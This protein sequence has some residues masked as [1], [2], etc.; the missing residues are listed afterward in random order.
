MRLS[1]TI[2]M[3]CLAIAVCVVLPVRAEAMRAGGFTE[4]FRLSDSLVPVALEISGGYLTGESREYVYEGSHK[5]SQLEWQLRDIYMVG[6]NVSVGA[7]DWLVVNVGGWMAVNDHAGRMTDYD[8][9]QEN[10]L[11]WTD[12]SI[13]T[14]KL[15]R[16]FMLDTNV[17]TPL[18]LN[19]HFSVVPMVG[20]K[21][22]N[23][24]WT[25]RDGSGIYSV[26]GWHDTPV[27]FNGK[28]ID[29]EQWY[30]VP[31]IG[32]SA[33]ANYEGF[34]LDAYARG[35]IYAWAEDRDNHI[36]RSTIF[37]GKFTHM[38]YY[39]LGVKAGYA[40]TDRFSLALAYDYQ[41]FLTTK[42]DVRINDRTA[43]DRSYEHKGGGVDHHSNMFS[44]SLSYL[45]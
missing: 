6:A 40:F 14:A 41:K 30:Y 36:L 2:V 9:T 24:K 17:Q 37:K 28:V 45:F 19:D 23:W 33:S 32:L 22:D 8:W 20:F 25:A 11:M 10:E 3:W 21:F 18:H 38:R 26:N 44:V 34:T 5:L 35:T 4:N 39:G 12:R 16:G 43:G 42:G 31:Y 15:E 27:T 1:K 13:H 29:Y 7:T